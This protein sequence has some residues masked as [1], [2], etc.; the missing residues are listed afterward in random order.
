[1]DSS[2]PDSSVWGDAAAVV[3]GKKK[4]SKAEKCYEYQ[5]SLSIITESRTPKPRRVSSCL[6]THKWDYFI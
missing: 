4:R 2:V 3:T 1:M 6:P 5:N